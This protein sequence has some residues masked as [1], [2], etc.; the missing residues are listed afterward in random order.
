[1]QQNNHSSN[2][3]N[4]LWIGE[5]DHWMDVNYLTEACLSYS[6]FISNNLFP[7]LI[8]KLFKYI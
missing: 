8:N 1:M 6:K 5:L 2:K 4:S 3:N 7:L